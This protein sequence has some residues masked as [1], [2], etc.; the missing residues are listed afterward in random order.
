MF[1]FHDQYLQN[2]D[3][4]FLL[5]MHPVNCTIYLVHLENLRWTW[6][7]G[8]DYL[9]Y[10]IIFFPPET[11]FS[12]RHPGL[13]FLCVNDRQQL[14]SQTHSHIDHLG[15]PNSAVVSARKKVHIH[16]RAGRLFRKSKNRRYGEG[17]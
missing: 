15:E 5:F 17:R 6:W 10:Q 7:N 3:F 9:T 4:R 2:N 11:K 16:L 12:V 13:V 8:R 14:T 1:F